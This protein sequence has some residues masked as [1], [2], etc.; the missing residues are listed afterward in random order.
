MRQSSGFSHHFQKAITLLGAVAFCL[1]VMGHTYAQ[2]PSQ[3]RPY[4]VYA[5][6]EILYGKTLPLLMVL[7]GGGGNANFMERHLP[8]LKTF[9]NEYGFVVAFVN[10]NAG[11]RPLTQNMRTWNAGGGCCGIAARQKKDDIPYLN[12]VVE[13]ISRIYP[14]NPKG[15]FLLGHS[16]G[17]MMSYRYACETGRV[18]GIIPISG[19]LLL[20]ECANGNGLKVL[21]LHGVADDIVPIAGGKK[22]FSRPAYP[23]LT[24]STYVMQT[25]GADVKVEI[26][27]NTS[28]KLKDVNRALYDKKGFGIAEQT[29]SFMQK[30]LSGK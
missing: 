5:P 25:A 1:V 9:A 18:A 14:I 4:T 12:H 10:G 13:N 16:N 21:H 11:N 19:P 23:P 24:Q 22:K 7:H 29:V 17:A 8:N 26:F 6:Q 30:V 2:I 27:P 3:S 20:N 28:H 15:V